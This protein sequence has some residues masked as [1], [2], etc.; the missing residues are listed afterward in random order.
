MG[1]ALEGRNLETREQ[2]ED[3]SDENVWERSKESVSKGSP[4]EEEKKERRE[5]LFSI[6]SFS[7]LF[8][9]ACKKP[10]YFKSFYYKNKYKSRENNVMNS[11]GSVTQLQLFSTFGHYY[12]ISSSLFFPLKYFKTKH[13]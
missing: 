13:R 6:H 11:H 10:L 4:S 12:L 1:S 5:Y 2:Q 3:Y 8:I 9:L 7:Y